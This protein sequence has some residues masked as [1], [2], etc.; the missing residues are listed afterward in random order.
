MT[1]QLYFFLGKEVFIYEWADSRPSNLTGC[2]PF[3]PIKVNQLK[4][5]WFFASSVLFVTSQNITKLRILLSTRIKTI[6]VLH[7]G[8]G[9]L[10]Q[11]KNNEMVNFF[12]AYF[13]F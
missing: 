9:G 7:G 6:F 5:H 2:V 12:G 10:R 4:Y 11:C 8:L 3:C 1:V 13:Y